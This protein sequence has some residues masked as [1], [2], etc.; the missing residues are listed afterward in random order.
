VAA[1]LMCC[2]RLAGSPAA[3]I[4]VDDYATYANY[5]VIEKYAALTATVG[6]MAVFQPSASISI[7]DL[8]AAIAEYSEDWR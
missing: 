7:P 3:R 1:T 2:L 5:H 6:R 8:R 4:F